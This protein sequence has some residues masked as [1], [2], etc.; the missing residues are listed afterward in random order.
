MNHA[1]R[2]A[3]QGDRLIRPQELGELG[4]ILRFRN[5]R[6]ISKAQNY[7]LCDKRSNLMVAGYMS[8]SPKA[9]PFLGGESMTGSHNQ[10]LSVALY[11][12][13]LDSSKHNMLLAFLS[14]RKTLH[15]FRVGQ[16]RYPS[17]RVYRAIGG[18]GKSERDTKD[19]SIF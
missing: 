12:L 7:M 4:D 16:I 17:I 2:K 14:G 10:N 1:P 13:S 6:S 19:I 3:V 18:E 8:L 5:S 9:F 11:V 15:T